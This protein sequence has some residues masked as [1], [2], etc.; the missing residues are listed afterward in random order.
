MI[1]RRFIKREKG[2]IVFNVGW[3]L[4]IGRVVIRY[5][6]QDAYKSIGIT[7]EYGSENYRILSADHFE[8][9]KN[10]QNKNDKQ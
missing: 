6:R 5:N 7:L 1:W 8:R 10:V 9:K 3:A 2:K 4:Q